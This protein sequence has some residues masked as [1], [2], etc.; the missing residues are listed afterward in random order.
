VTKSKNNTFVEQ[1]LQKIKNAY[2][3]KTDASL[4]RFLNMRP[5]TLAMQKK[6][7]SLNW[8]RI[9]KKCSDLD[10]NWLFHDNNPG[11]SNGSPIRIRFVKQSKLI[12]ISSTSKYYEDIG[13]ILIPSNLMPDRIISSANLSSCLLVKMDQKTKHPSI[14]KGNVLLINTDL[15]DPLD[16]HPYLIVLNGRTLLSRIEFDSDTRLILK[17]QDPESPSDPDVY[18]SKNVT[19]IGRVLWTG[20]RPNFIT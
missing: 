20:S 3:I 11:A 8:L 2:N 10:K 7:G 13:E 15:S 12:P 18:D 16:N 14:Q 17:D 4:A 1:V 6:R 5:N 9:F 19:L